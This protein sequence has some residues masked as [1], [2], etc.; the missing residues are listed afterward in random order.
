M[1]TIL[2][3][4]FFNETSMNNHP[5]EQNDAVSVG[6]PWGK[7]RLTHDFSGALQGILTQETTASRSVFIGRDFFLFQFFA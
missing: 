5:W 6:K 1:P 3:M 2:F 4:G 7:G